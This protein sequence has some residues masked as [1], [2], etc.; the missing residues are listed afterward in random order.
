MSAPRFFKYFAFISYSRKDEAFAKRLQHFLMGFKLPGKLRKK[1]PDKPKHLRPIYRDKTNMVIH[2]LDEAIIQGLKLSRNLIVICSQN[3]ANN[4]KNGKN[5]VDEEV[6]NFLKIDQENKHC[7]I[8][9]LLR[10]KGGPSTKECTP[11]AVLELG[12]LAADVSDKGE[13]RVFSDVA[14]KILGL[15]P[16]ELWDWWERSQKFRRRWKWTFRIIGAFMVTLFGGCIWYFNTL[17]ISYFT[18]YEECNN[19]PVGIHEISEDETKL[20]HSHYR[21]TS[22]GDDP[23][24]IENLNA[25]GRPVDTRE[26][27]RHEARPVSITV[28]Y[29]RD[30]RTTPFQQTYFNIAGIPEQTRML[31]ENS[32]T[33][34]ATNTLGANKSAGISEAASI[35]AQFEAYLS[36]STRFNNQNVERFQVERDK[37]GFIS[38]ELYRNVHNTTPVRNNDGAWG[39]QYKRDDKGR[40]LVITYTDY[41]GTPQPNRFGIGSIRYEYHPTEEQVQRITYHD[42]QGA[43]MSGP[44]GYAEARYKWRSG[45]LQ[46]V[47]FYDA[48]RR[49]C[50][51]NEGYAGY[52]SIHDQNGH[53]ISRMYFDVKGLSSS[54][55]DGVAK[56]R[57]TYDEYGHRTSESYYDTANRPCL[58]T[59]GY[60]ILR[61]DY[62]E[63][64]NPVSESYY[65]SEGKACLSKNGIANARITYDEQNRP[66]CVAIYDAEGHPCLNKKGIA[67]TR[68]SFDDRGNITQIATYGLDG[69]PCMS[70]DNFAKARIT[71]DQHRH[72]TSVAYFDKQ[73]RPCLCKEGYAKFSATYDKGGNQTSV[74]YFDTENHPCSGKDGI[75]KKHYSFDKQGNMTQIATYGADGRPCMGSDCYA[76]ARVTYCAQF[77]DTEG[78]ICEC[79][80]GFASVHWTYDEH[81]NE[82]SRTYYDAAGRQVEPDFGGSMGNA[83]EE[84]KEKDID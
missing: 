38:K 37:R 62:D 77:Y 73:G 3:S 17:H 58:N 4:N 80:D 46:K 59:N 42:T 82:I 49:P 28:D 15:D 75:A 24:L 78:R 61:T 23:T 47:S 29:H 70:S 52:H 53:E 36:P 40:P 20:L 10:K 43:L 14:A 50:L 60:A 63:R 5:W 30:T 81:G 11:P 8:P 13:K 66:I 83:E 54:G 34:R 25:E 45:N 76:E 41:K 72:Q 84:K 39:C 26:L 65:D 35:Y 44:N 33:F 2:K 69:R 68:F 9:V 48:E 32:T 12:L 51:N 67:E 21:I 56:I 16:D 22:L 31:R 18:D 7:V 6:R 79:K 55:N 71:Y 19:V 27:P 1:Y 57:R 64:G 74:A